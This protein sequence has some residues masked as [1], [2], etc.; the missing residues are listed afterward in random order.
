MILHYSCLFS[1]FFIG[2]FIF[3]ILRETLYYKKELKN[4]RNVHY[5]RRKYILFD[6]IMSLLDI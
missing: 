5:K 1:E 3:Y 2:I 4:K 6:I